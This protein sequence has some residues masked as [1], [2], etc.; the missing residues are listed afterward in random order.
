MIFSKSDSDILDALGSARLVAQFAQENEIVRQNRTFREPLHHVGA[1][2]ADAALQAGL[3]YRTVV[4]TR[5][6]RIVREFPEARTLSGTLR[7]IASVGV[8]DFLSWRHQTK[9]LRFIC[10]AD[11]LRNEGIDNFQHLRTWLQDPACREK[12]LIIHGVGPKTADYLCSLVGLDCIAVDRH[13][14]TFARDA[15]V[16]ATDYDHL[17]IVISF[18][19]DLLGVPRRHFDASIWAY[20][21][22]RSLSTQI[23]QHT[24]QLPFERPFVAA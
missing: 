8:A 14:Q 12:L 19:A 24:A 13:I 17:K 18:A 7:A 10:L 4:K 22:N 2:L 16:T 9:T 11:L 15:G 21:S 5:V 20:V 6:D 3:N 1:I 23:L